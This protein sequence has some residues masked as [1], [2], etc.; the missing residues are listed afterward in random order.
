VQTAPD[1]IQLRLV[2]ERALTEEEERQ[3]AAFAQK[4]FGYPFRI[5]VVPVSEIAR[6]PGGKYEEFVSLMVPG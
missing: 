5:E 6:G 4:A 3:T 1:T 2:L